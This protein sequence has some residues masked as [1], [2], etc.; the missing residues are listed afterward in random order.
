MYYAGQAFEI[1]ATEFGHLK[2]RQMKAV[3]GFMKI[4]R[5][6]QSA[7]TSERPASEVRSLHAHHKAGEPIREHTIA[8]DDIT[9]LIIDL[10]TSEDVEDFLKRL[11]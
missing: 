5:T 9:D 2:D 4:H 11:G 6:N 8:A 10:E 3:E 7:Q 1:D